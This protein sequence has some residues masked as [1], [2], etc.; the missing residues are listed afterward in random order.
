MPDNDS[1]TFYFE[2]RLWF[3]LNKIVKNIVLARNKAIGFDEQSVDYI[4]I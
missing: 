1:D 2:G 4:A 3:S